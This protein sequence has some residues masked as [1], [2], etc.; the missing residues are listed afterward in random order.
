MNEQHME[1]LAKKMTHLELA[2]RASEQVNFLR[3][4]ASSPEKK[5]SVAAHS[6]EVA[7]LLEDARADIAEYI[8]L[9]VNGEQN[10]N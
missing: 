2:I 3:L 10:V 8:M 1:T 9:L 7:V 5:Q 4:M 6:Y